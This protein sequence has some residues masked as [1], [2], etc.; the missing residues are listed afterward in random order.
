[1][2]KQNAKRELFVGKDT[3]KVVET[4]QRAY[5]LLVVLHNYVDSWANAFVHEFWNSKVRLKRTVNTHIL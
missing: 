4:Q 1:M 2:H 3:D 5:D